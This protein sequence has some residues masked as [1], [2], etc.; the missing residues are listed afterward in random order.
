MDHTPL[1]KSGPGPGLS[2]IGRPESTLSW[3]HFGWLKEI[4]EFVKDPEICHFGGLGG[5][6]GP[7]NPA[8]RRGAKPAPFGRVS[9]AAGA[10]QTHKMADFRVLKKILNSR[11]KCSHVAEN[12]P[13][14]GYL[15]AIWLEIFGPV[16]SKILG[17][18]RPSGP[19]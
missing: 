3:L 8:K 12:V 6:G 19:P 5:P 1:E 14:T 10:A 2:N 4:L 17:R 7:G 18:N 9:R 13:K 15:K 11:P 16:F